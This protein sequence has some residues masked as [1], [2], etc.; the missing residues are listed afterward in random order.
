MTRED[1][2]RKVVVNIKCLNGK[3]KTSYF[4]FSKIGLI[5]GPKNSGDPVAVLENIVDAKDDTEENTDIEGQIVC[6]DIQPKL[7]LSKLKYS[8]SQ[9]ADTTIIKNKNINLKQ[10]SNSVNAKYSSSNF[11]NDLNQIII[12]HDQD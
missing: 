9:Q 2:I 12:F 7:K 11:L 5:Q 1:L 10:P 4:Q 3:K 6:K 8:T